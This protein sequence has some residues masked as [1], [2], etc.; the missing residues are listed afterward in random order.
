MNMKRG[1]CRT[2]DISRGDWAKTLGLKE[3]R[4]RGRCCNANETQGFSVG[5]GTRKMF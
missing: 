2:A 1:Q 4:G 5:N 3:A